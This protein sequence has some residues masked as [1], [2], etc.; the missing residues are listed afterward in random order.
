MKFVIAIEPGNKRTAHGVAVPDLPGCFSAGDSIEEAFD[1]AAQA[2]ELHCE[3]LAEG[4]GDLPTLKTMTEHQANREYKGWVWGVVD[5][6]IERYFGPAE[7]I[8]ITVPARVLRRIDEYARA[9]G[10]SRSGFLTQAAITEMAK[11]VE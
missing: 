10:Q 2:I 6:P 11:S 5:V 7:K 3:L 4:G 9:H 1:N 8:N